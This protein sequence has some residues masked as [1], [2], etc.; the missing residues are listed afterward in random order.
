MNC[1]KVLK[2]SVTG[3]GEQLHCEG[4]YRCDIVKSPEI[5]KMIT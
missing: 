4:V 5:K 3:R 2:T 1:K